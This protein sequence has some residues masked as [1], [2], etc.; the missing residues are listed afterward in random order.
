MRRLPAVG[1]AHV[2]SGAGASC[3]PAQ[4]RNYSKTGMSRSSGPIRTELPKG[5]VRHAPSSM[6]YAINS[7]PG[8]PFFEYSSGTDKRLN[9]H[10]EM[11]AFIGSR[12]IG[13][14]YLFRGEDW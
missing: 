4:F 6:V 11:A 8:L 10:Q 7:R 14:W 3:H 12:A 9:G 5:T 13:Q 2:G 1:T